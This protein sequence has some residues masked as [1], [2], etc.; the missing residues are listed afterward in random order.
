MVRPTELPD[1]VEFLQSAM[2]ATSSKAIKD[3]LASLPIVPENQYSFHEVDPESGWREGNF[4]WYPV[5][6]ELG[7]LFQIEP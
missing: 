1:P 3:L 6:R 5:G 7:N 4:H 2:A